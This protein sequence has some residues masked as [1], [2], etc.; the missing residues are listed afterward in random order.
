MLI[1]FFFE[2]RQP[3]TSSLSRLHLN[4]WCQAESYGWFSAIKL[5]ARLSSKPAVAENIVCVRDPEEQHRALKIP[6]EHL[7]RHA[8]HR[9]S[10]L[11]SVRHM[12]METRFYGDSPYAPGVST[13][14]EAVCT[15]A[16]LKSVAT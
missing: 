13:T 7:A 6:E 4:S 16:R 1:E 15:L 12:A 14:I 9:I 2:L 5:I 10:L 3:A 11:D 8:F